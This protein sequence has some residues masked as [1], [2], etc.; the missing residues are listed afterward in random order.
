[1]SVEGK[2]IRAFL[3]DSSEDSSLD[4][5]YAD[6]EVKIVSTSPEKRVRTGTSEHSEYYASDQKVILEGGAP[7]LVDSIKGRTAGKQLTW[8][9]NNDRLLVDGLESKPAESTLRKKK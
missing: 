1:L 8:Y 5:A 2:T 3:K 4:K 7:L 6:G 9:A